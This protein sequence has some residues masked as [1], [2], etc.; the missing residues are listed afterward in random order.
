M[1][2]LTL[3]V[4]HDIQDPSNAGFDMSAIS[5]L[6]GA[7]LSGSSSLLNWSINVPQTSTSVPEELGTLTGNFYNSGGSV[8]GNVTGATFLEYPS[9]QA[10]QYTGPLSGVNYSSPVLGYSI[11]IAPNINIGSFLNSGGL[12]I[13]S[14]WTGVLF[15][16][17]NTITGTPYNDIIWGGLA[18]S[19]IDG[20][21]GIDTLILD[22]TR[23]NATISN[24]PSSG[25]T[26][27]T[28]VAGGVTD[29]ITNIE[30]LQFS[31]INVA[32]DF[33]Y[34]GHAEIAANVLGAVFGSSSVTN[35]T[36]VGIGLSLLDN[37]MNYNELMTYAINAKLGATPSNS[38]LVNLLYN[39]VVGTLPTASDLTYYE[40]LLANGTL[41]QT[42][43]AIMAADTPQNATNINLT[44]LASTGLEYVPSHVYTNHL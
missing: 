19:T 41:S 27:F 15:G 20:G 30:R 43:L 4:L 42:G 7:A 29:N 35:T 5:P 31:D 6:V 22:G 37:G 34:Y 24:T 2:T 8:A 36:F 17:T 12:G 9:S 28:V 3:S 11:Q 18:N 14:Q 32:L 23:A 39:N 38:T 40:N 13:L 25:S 10:S 33:G 16:T 26:A 44:G 1:T 21:G